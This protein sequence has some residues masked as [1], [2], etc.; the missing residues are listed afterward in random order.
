ME[1]VRCM[2]FGMFVFGLGVSPL[3]VVQETIIVRF[4]KTHG[5]GLGMAIGLVAGKAS[6]FIAAR[7][8]YPLTERFGPHAP[9]Y[10]AAILATISFLI[11]LVYLAVSRWIIAGTGTEMES[12]ELRQEARRISLQDVSEAQALRQV[13]EKKRIRNLREVADLGDLFW[14]CVLFH[15]RFLQGL[16]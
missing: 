2:T 12:S 1:D 5:L 10:A 7:T 3:A 8:S 4:F 13:A 6:S 16:T 11:N 9:F 14:A 15:L